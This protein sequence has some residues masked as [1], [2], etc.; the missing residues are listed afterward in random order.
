MTAAIALRY[1][2]G[3]VA[4]IPFRTGTTWDLDGTSVPLAPLTDW[5]LVYRHHNPMRARLLEPFVPEA[6]WSA[7]LDLIGAPP[8]FDGLRPECP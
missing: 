6:E 7:F 1:R 8:G 5:L 2:S 3:F 4:R